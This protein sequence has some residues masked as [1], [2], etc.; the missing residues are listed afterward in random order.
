MSVPTTIVVRSQHLL[1]HGRVIRQFV[2]TRPLQDER[3]T[4]EGK[5]SRDTFQK[6]VATRQL[7]PLELFCLFDFDFAI[8]VHHPHVSDD[9]GRVQLGKSP[10]CTMTLHVKCGIRVRVNIIDSQSRDTTCG[11]NTNHFKSEP[12]LDLESCPECNHPVAEFHVC[13]PFDVLSVS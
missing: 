12:T 6:S 5:P 1:E 7:L 2:F 3:K 13:S 8:H 4:S 11:Q 9:H 10:S